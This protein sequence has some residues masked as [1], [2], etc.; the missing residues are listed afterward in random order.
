MLNEIQLGPVTIHMY[1]LMI[2]LGYVTAYLIS[3]LR[4][5][6]KGLNEDILWGILICSILG[7]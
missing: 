4:A 3:C 1:G 2:G 5:R 7:I 6:K